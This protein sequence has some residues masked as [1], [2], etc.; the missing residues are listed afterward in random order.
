LNMPGEE[1]G[2]ASHAHAGLASVSANWPVA[3]V[4]HTLGYLAATFAVALIVYEKLGLALLRSAWINLDVV[5]CVALIA[6]GIIALFAV[7]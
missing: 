7:R 2:H 6:T 3:L 1:R 4:V 5:W